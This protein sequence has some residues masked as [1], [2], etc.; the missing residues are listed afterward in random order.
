MVFRLALEQWI[1]T[2]AK[3]F[4]MIIIFMASFVIMGVA[5]YK[6]EEL[7]YQR[8]VA[9]KTFS[10][11]LD[12]SYI[13]TLIGQNNDAGSNGYY[14]VTIETIDKLCDMEEIIS[15]AEI[16]MS[17][18]YIASGELTDII[19]KRQRENL[20]KNK[21]VFDNLS[22]IGDECIACIKMNVSGWDLCR[23]SL[24]KGSS[25]QQLTLND[26]EVY[27]YLGYGF[28][29]INIG[30]TFSFGP[31]KT[32]V[33]AGIF[34]KGQRWVRN[35]VGRD[36]TSYYDCDYLAL[37][38]IPSDM[39]FC[40]SGGFL[41]LSAKEG[42]DYKNVKEIVVD[43]F[44]RIGTEVSII[45]LSAAFD[46]FESMYEVSYAVMWKGLVIAVISAAMIQICMQM[47]E[48]ME[49]RRRYGI[50]FA[51]GMVSVKLAAIVVLKNAFNFVLAGVIA[52]AI[53]YRFIDKPYIFFEMALS[54]IIIWQLIIFAV[55]QLVPV[56]M[57]CRMKPTELMK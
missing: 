42:T 33:V 53:G 51:N 15:I 19:R 26:N 54:K 31:E 9:D 39:E 7:N 6:N 57:I 56:I 10:T 37:I 43:A 20:L 13:A 34:D 11:G 48:L 32:A 35:N 8:N 55:S 5:V 47:A 46:K 41:T 14:D 50:Y 21:E 1:R 22:Y 23:T 40:Y 3:M 16:D 18:Y 38:L 27:C 44:D 4:L 36:E 49:D 52:F 28:K 29:D 2:F 12:N 17:E 30:E 45:S 25:P 24:F